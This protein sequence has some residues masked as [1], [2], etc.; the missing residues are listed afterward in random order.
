[1]HGQ[2]MPACR[3]CD[4]DDADADADGSVH[5]HP[6]RAFPT[7]PGHGGTSRDTTIEIVGTLRT[8][9]ALH[10]R[11]GFSMGC[12]TTFMRALYS[13][14]HQQPGCAW[15]IGAHPCTCSTQQ[16]HNTTVAC[17]ASACHRSPLPQHILLPICC[18]CCC[19]FGVCVCVCVLG[20]MC[21]YAVQTC[22]YLKQVHHYDMHTHPSHRPN[23]ST[24]YV[25]PTKVIP[26]HPP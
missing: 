1:M 6:T 2:P 12:V 9:R 10:V 4:D 24:S 11:T 26:N 8:L 15:F 18:C 17:C 16:T 20:Y 22:I 19:V 25:T 13:I 7:P 5:T 23:T 14:P 3:V 21:M